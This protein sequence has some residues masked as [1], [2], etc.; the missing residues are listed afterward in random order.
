MALP[1]ARNLKKVGAPL[2]WGGCIPSR[3]EGRLARRASW[4]RDLPRWILGPRSLVTREP[5][6]RWRVAPIKLP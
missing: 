2:S 6:D 5:S 4:D 3:E 1:V